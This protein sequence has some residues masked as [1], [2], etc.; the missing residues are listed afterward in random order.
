MCI[1]KRLLMQ[2]I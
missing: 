2:F 1:N